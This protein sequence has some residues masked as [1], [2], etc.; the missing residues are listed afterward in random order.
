MLQ[1]RQGGVVVHAAVAAKAKSNADGEDLDEVHRLLPGIG[2][3]VSFQLD[4]A[5]PAVGQT[6]A[7][8]NLRGMTGA[9]VLAITRGDQGLI[10]STAKEVLRAGDVLA[11]AGSHEAIAAAKAM[12]SP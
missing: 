10:A 8:L 5:S 3:P 1:A 2:E 4:E 7:S 11:L 9:T 12:L 6:L